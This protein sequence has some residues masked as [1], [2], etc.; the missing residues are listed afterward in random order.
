MPVRPIER[1]VPRSPVVGLCAYLA[2][3]IAVGALLAFPVYA[4]LQQV[5]DPAFDSVLQRVA[6]LALLLLLPFYLASGRTATARARGVG[7][8]AGSL[9]GLMTREAF[10]FGCSGRAFRRGLARGFALGILVVSPLIAV[11]LLL[12][13]RAPVEGAASVP[14]IAAYAGYALVAAL[15]IGLVEESYFRGA[16]LAPLGHLPAWLAVSLVSVVYAAVHFLGAPLP[17]DDVGWASGLAS[18]ARS[19]LPLDAFLAL[20]A[21]GLFLGALRVRF[22]HIGISA[23]FH[24]GWVW[25]TKLNQAY[26][27]IVPDSEWRFLEGSFGGTMGTL[28]LVW[29]GLLGIGWYAVASARRARGRKRG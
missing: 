24:A 7:R 5:A 9:R 6:G 18:I 12:G 26:T 10:G 4:A 19:E 11:F 15:M 29:I 2:A 16:L 8:D 14:D 23:G 27:D 28:G 22:G 20:F 25:L 13:V 3:A 21:A 1:L 17:A